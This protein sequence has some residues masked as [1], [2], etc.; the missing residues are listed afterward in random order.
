[1][2]AAFDQMWLTAAVPTAIGVGLLPGLH[3]AWGVGVLVVALALT[4][5]YKIGVAQPGLAPLGP[6]RATNATNGV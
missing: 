6:V 2:G 4:I 5:P 1:M 3:W